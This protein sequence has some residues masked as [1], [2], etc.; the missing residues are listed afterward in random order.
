MVKKEE[1]KYIVFDD[2]VKNVKYFNTLDVAKNYAESESL[3]T[4]LRKH[5]D[6]LNGKK[7]GVVNRLGIWT[8]NK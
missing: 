1:S 3:E 4:G 6:I 8:W 2:N 7:L 5:L